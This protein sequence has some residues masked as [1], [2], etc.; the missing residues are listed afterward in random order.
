MNGA[1]PVSVP[2]FR[3]A[4]DAHDEA[5]VLRCLRSGWLTTGPECQ[6]LEEAVRKAT[7][8]P[9]AVS[10]SS[11]TAALHAALAYRN[12]DSTDEVIVPSYTFI[13]SA[14]AV[15]HAGGRP[16]LCDV[17]DDSLCIDVAD[18][19]RRITPRTRGIVAVDFAGHP[20][21][22]AALEDL[23]TR[24]MWKADRL[25]LL[26]DAAHS[27]G[28]S[29]ASVSVGGAGEDACFSF[30]ANKN[31]TTGEGGMLTTHNEHLADFARRF[32]L[33]GMD[34]T[35][36]NRYGGIWK[37]YDVLE[38]GYKYNLPDLNAALGVGQVERLSEI[39]TARRTV[40]RA[41]EAALRDL[42]LVLPVMHE[43]HAW[44]LYVIR[45]ER[46]DALMTHLQTRG[47]GCAI[48]YPPIHR[49]SVFG[50]PDTWFP[51]STRAYETVLSLPIY[52]G[53]SSDE[54]TYVV[55]SIREFFQ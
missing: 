13:A 25:F 36:W 14:S 8:A 12:L 37:P 23:C 39:T 16:V 54:Q 6:R 22:L 47:V 51:I 52:P 5:R 4:I 48:H 33:H 49:M 55:D 53:L 35:A 15:I 29:E 30:Y 46:R 11:A 44:H 1:S 24:H 34:V 7:G 26:R 28:A 3:A 20:A 2:F 32:R 43:G 18:V 41:Y 38:I 45:T 42:P 19:E 40:A 10:F 27:L 9:Y 17:K 50:L 31:I 21:D